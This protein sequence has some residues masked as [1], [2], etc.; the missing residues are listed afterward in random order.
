M[1]K[2]L[3]SMLALLIILSGCSPKT[4]KFQTEFTD[5]FDTVTIV[6]AYCTNEAEF[7]KYVEVIRDEMRRMHHFF[8]IYND[9][10]GINNIKTINDMA[11]IAPVEC[12][13]EIIELINEG[14]EAYEE[15]GGAVNIALGSVLRLWHD[16]RDAAGRDPAGAA[17]PDM[18]ALL[19]AVPHTD[20]T[21]LVVDTDA[22]T[23]YLEDA[24]MSLDVGAFAKGWAVERAA[25]A[26]QEAG[27]KSGLISAGGNVLVIGAPLDGRDAWGV[28]IQNPN[29][30]EYY[31]VV[32]AT[33]LA[34]VTSGDYERFFT[35]DG[36]NYHHIIDPVTLFPA[37]HF[38]SVTILHPDSGIADMLSTPLFV[39]PYEQGAALAEKYSAE[40]LWIHPDGT[41]S[42][43]DGYLAKSSTLN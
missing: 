36:V 18:D 29:G 3:L 31:D 19:A 34:A 17:V 27:L 6:T 21:K 1:K 26:A 9:Y 10:N 40:A 33:D 4:E 38:R 5:V 35:V 2:W 30:G 16:A 8:D 32:A 11:G 12:A 23:V 42:A 28:A 14:I 25:R 41:F 20:I 13:P 22:S 24:E 39:L 37:T 7:K 15:S 43:T